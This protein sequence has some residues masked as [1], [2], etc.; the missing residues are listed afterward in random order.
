MLAIV[1]SRPGGEAGEHCPAPSPTLLFFFM[2]GYWYC[3]FSVCCKCQGRYGVLYIGVEFE[4]F[5]FLLPDSLQYLYSIWPQV[6]ADGDNRRHV[7]QINQSC[8][9]S[10]RQPIQHTIIQSINFKKSMLVPRRR[11]MHLVCSDHWY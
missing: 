6:R 11:A 10:S 8:N 9:R 1:R 4:L 3:C 7:M 2:R 5:V